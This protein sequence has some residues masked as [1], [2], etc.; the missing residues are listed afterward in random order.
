MKT[1]CNPLWAAL[2]AVGMT[3]TAACAS[4]EYGA[5]VVK[6]HAA[7][8]L[9]GAEPNAAELRLPVYF[10]TRTQWLKEGE[11]LQ[12]KPQDLERWLHRHAV[13]SQTPADVELITYEQRMVVKHAGQ[14]HV[15]TFHPT[16]DRQPVIYLPKE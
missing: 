9:S 3:L 6:V 15:Q 12:D 2:V 7:A 14:F 1:L 16:K 13:V 10:V 11:A 8:H 4:Q 5:R